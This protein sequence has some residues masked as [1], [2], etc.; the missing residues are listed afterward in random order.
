MTAFPIK[1]V[2][3]KTLAVGPQ[4]S[5]IQLLISVPKRHFKHAVDRNRVK[6]QLREAFRKNCSLLGS[7]LSEG[8]HV[9]L[10]FVWMAPT[11]LDSAKVVARVVSLLCRIADKVGTVPPAQP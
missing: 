3:M 4:E 9:D 2:Y 5:N 1:T 11:H 8:E 6:R 7:R 10:A